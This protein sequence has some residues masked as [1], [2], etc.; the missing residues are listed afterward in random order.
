M[1]KIVFGFLSVCGILSAIPANAALPEHCA[2]GEGDTCTACESGYVLNNGACT[3]QIKIAT[4]K[5]V[6]EEFAAAEAN[7]ATTVQTIESVVSRTIDQAGDISRLQAEK[8]TRPNETCPAGKKC[9]LVMDENDIPHWYEIIEAVYDFV[10]NWFTPFNNAGK[11]GAYI[12]TSSRTNP[13]SGATETV[14]EEYNGFYNG[15]G[16][17]R[18]TYVDSSTS[19]YRRPFDSATRCLPGATRDTGTP[20]AGICYPETGVFKTLAEGEWALVYNGSE[21]SSTKKV[22]AS[23][24]YGTSKCTT[25]AGPNSYATSNPTKF[26]ELTPAQQAA[27]AVEPNSTNKSANAGYLNCWCKMTALGIPNSGETIASGQSTAGTIYPLPESSSA[28]V[29]FGTYSSAANCAYGC[30][31]RCALYVRDRAGFRAAVLGWAD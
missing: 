10:A 6:D 13:T 5:F 29:F 26:S 12:K 31:N 22:P 18:Q 15:A 1:K 9:L 19:V 21:G 25:V 2:T 3:E 27:W 20:N 8:Q 24:V 11:P 23:V 17:W 16:T 14:Y 28:W 7:L 30:A 4:T